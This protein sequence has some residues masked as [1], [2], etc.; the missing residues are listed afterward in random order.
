M[1]KLSARLKPHE[2]LAS[3]VKSEIDAASL[4][5]SL[6]EKVRSRLLL[7]KLDF[8]IFEEKRHRNILERLYAQRFPDQKLELPI[9][10]FLPASLRLS[11]AGLDVPG[12]FRLALK[13]EKFSEEY[14]LAARSKMKEVASS[15]K[16]F[17]YLSRV[18]GSHYF[19]VRSEFDLLER[20]PD[21]YQV[22]EAHLGEDL[23]HVG[24]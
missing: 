8:L 1:V 7:R 3:A 12:L 24:P 9:R 13:A 16:I 5:A 19:I 11:P 14:Y 6:K 18:E 23:V 10:S 15:R 2:V 20:F 21:S 4:Y 17:D 22:E